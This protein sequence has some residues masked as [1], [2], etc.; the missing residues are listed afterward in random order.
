[1]TNKEMDGRSRNSLISWLTLSNPPTEMIGRTVGRKTNAQTGRT[2]PQSCKKAKSKGNE[3]IHSNCNNNDE[4]PKA[5]TSK[6]ADPTSRPHAH[7]HARLALPAPAPQTSSMSSFL[8]ASADHSPP[9]VPPGMLGSCG[10]G[11]C[12]RLSPR[13]CR[14]GR[15]FPVKIKDNIWILWRERL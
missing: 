12:V 11:I 5:F 13:L 7:T 14:E 9:Q 2:G 10:R 15:L 4:R 6:V 1:M 8:K 3:S